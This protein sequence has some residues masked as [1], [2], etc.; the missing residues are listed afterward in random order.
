VAVKR[1]G[2]E[3]KKDQH[4]E[5]TK[6]QHVEL[7]IQSTG[8]AGAQVSIK[9]QVGNLHED[10]KKIHQLLDLLGMPKGTEVRITTITGSV[11]VR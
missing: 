1:A 11:I 8:S 9:G 7:E 10:P 5:N 6:D 3:M 4:V 2:V